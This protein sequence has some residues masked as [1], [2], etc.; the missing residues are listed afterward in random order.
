MRAATG[1]KKYAPPNAEIKHLIT[2]LIR[3]I[4]PDEG[5]QFPADLK[6]KLN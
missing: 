3:Q 6:A 1:R 2:G 5:G 4:D